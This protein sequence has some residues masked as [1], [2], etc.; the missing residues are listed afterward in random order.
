MI[1]DERRLEEKSLQVGRTEQD[2][3]VQSVTMMNEVAKRLKQVAELPSEKP[4]D[5]HPLTKV[6]FPDEAEVFTFMQGYDYPYR[7]YPY[8]EF[9]DK[10]DLIKKLSRNL[11]SGFYHGLKNTWLRWLLI[12]LIPTL[13]KQIFWACTYTFH[14]LIDRFQMRTNRY[15]QFVGELH[16]AASLGWSDESPKT[17]ELRK[18]LRDIE[19]MILEFDNAYRFRVQDILPELDKVALQDNPILEINRVLDI[20]ISREKTQEIKD[21]WRLLKL[22]TSYY[23]RF[24]K[25]LLKIITRVLLELDIAKCAMT[26]EDKYFAVPRKDYHFGFQ[27]NPSADDQKLIA[28]ALLQR[29]FDSELDS[30]RKLSTI[31]HDILSK[32]QGTEDEVKKLD[33]Q[34][35]NQLLQAEK[36]YLIKKAKI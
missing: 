31:E 2:Q 22:F 32:S 30:I 1:N 8:Y 12:P 23:L 25:K 16:R 6:E 19:C 11:Q 13:G 24:D 27:I 36:E 33:K 17:I 21:S 10:I 14:R 15:S 9:V 35:E 34:F 18:M 20:W 3:L 26:N 4:T 28:K 29:G 5:N 7:G